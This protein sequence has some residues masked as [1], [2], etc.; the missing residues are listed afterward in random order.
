MDQYNDAVQHPNT[1]FTDA[2]LRGGKVA[3][4]G[5]GIPLALGGGF[6]LTYTVT[7]AHRKFAVRCFHKPAPGL[8]TRYPT[9]SAAL[10]GGPNQAYFVGF[11]YQSNGILVNG[12]R[13]PI[14]KMDWVNGDT[15]GAYVETHYT[16]K[17]ALNNLRNEF[18]ALDKF[19]S[20]R[21]IAHGDLQ[22]GNVVV[23]GGL[24]LIDYDGM[25][26]PG[27]PIGQGL[28]IGQVHFQHPKRT[29]SQFGPQMDR[30]SFI[31]IELSLRAL[32]E[33][34]NLF[35][36]YSNGENIIFTASDFA[37]PSRSALFGEL[38]AIPALTASVDNFARICGASIGS[39]PT[40]DDFLA[41]RNIPAI[42]VV[43]GRPTGETQPP[44]YIGAYEVLDA[45]DYDAVLRSVGNRIELVGQVKSVHVGRTTRGARPYIFINFGDWHTRI[46][47]VNIWSDALAKLTAAPNASWRGKWLSVTGLVDPP[48]SGKRVRYTHLSITIIEAN[49]LREISEA[50]ARRRLA[51]QPKPSGSLPA[52]TTNKTIL[53]TLTGKGTTLL[54]TAGMTGQQ[55]PQLS[56]SAGRNQQILATIRSTSPATPSSRGLPAASG[57]AKT[58]SSSGVP[59]WVIVVGILLIILILLVFSAGHH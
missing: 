29:A 55:K 30:F 58:P 45:S 5:L 52:S 56:S 11:D 53:R 12:S 21:S 57:T 34:P 8:A 1:A 4:N 42:S 14:V 19:L 33:R 49:Q 40:L 7:A 20:A 16:D 13:Y 24:K 27:L 54:P 37:D 17:V 9:I 38:R 48:Y 32:L 47:K 25:Y 10:S 50:E 28:E 15:L 43:F 31:V 2:T 41:G 44:V 22:N 59:G 26:V 46:T 36:K 39:V 6:A 35:K 3:T 23:N 18:I 51:K